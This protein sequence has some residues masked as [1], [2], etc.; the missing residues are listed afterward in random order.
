ME[1]TFVKPAG[2]FVEPTALFPQPTTVPSDSSARLLFMPA[3]TET[4]SLKPSG[5]LVWP[6]SLS[7][8]ATIPPAG[9]LVWAWLSRVAKKHISTQTCK[10][11]IR[12][13]CSHDR[14]L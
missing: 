8:Q 1:V 5:T 10:A 9:R 3:E 6:L 2:I 7:P 4:T 12:L 14:F 13:N 11:K